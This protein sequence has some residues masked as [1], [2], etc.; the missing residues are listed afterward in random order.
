MSFFTAPF[1]TGSASGGSGSG[2]NGSNQAFDI[3]KE[4]LMALCMKLNKK[5]QSLE[6]K[7]HDLTRQKTR[8]LDERQFLADAISQISRV[9]VLM[10]H[11]DAAIEPVLHRETLSKW[12]V[13]QIQLIET[14]ESK[15]VD[16]E[17]QL[18]DAKACAAAAQV[19][20]DLLSFDPPSATLPISPVPTTTTSNVSTS[21][22]AIATES[23]NLTPIR[24]PASN[25]QFKVEI[26]V[27][28]AYIMIIILNHILIHYFLF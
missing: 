3:P 20:S 16:L 14:L 26:E 10:S 19:S 28:I 12:K 2:S 1:S 5:M 23:V 7:C 21:L 13:S 15:T 4:E 18:Q 25:E 6:S 17:R 22:P 24:T 27:H 8:L 11:D 9:N